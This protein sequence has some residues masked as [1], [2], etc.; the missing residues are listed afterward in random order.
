[1]T[2]LKS[3]PIILDHSPKHSSSA[4]YTVLTYG[5]DVR[6]VE[7]AI[8]K[9]FQYG[10]L[11]RTAVARQHQLHFLIVLGGGHDAVSKH[12]RYSVY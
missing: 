7:L 10:R 11:S 5:F 12:K 8:S 3:T 6:L 4:A 1:M 2:V 9:H